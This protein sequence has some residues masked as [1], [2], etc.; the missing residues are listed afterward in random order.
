MFINVH[1]RKLINSIDESCMLCENFFY[2]IRHH[3][4]FIVEV[5][6]HRGLQTSS[7]GFNNENQNNNENKNDDDKNNG[8]IQYGFIGFI[9]DNNIYAAKI[10]VWVLT[11]FS[12]GLLLQSTMSKEQKTVTFITWNDFVKHILSKGEVKSITVH[13]YFDLVQIELHDD[14]IIDGRQADHYQFN[15]KIFDVQNFEEK[16]RNAEISLGVKPENRVPVQ[17]ERREKIAKVLAV[18]V[19]AAILF[20]IYRSFKKQAKSV[21]SSF[22]KANFTIID[23]HIPSKRVGIKFKDV[24]GLKEAKLEVMEFVDYLIKPK[25]FSRLGAKVPKGALLL[26]PPGCGKTLLA[27]ALAT[28]AGVPFLVMAGSE[29]VEL[30]GGLGAARVRSL[31]SEARK[32]S[33]CII[34]IDEIDAIG[35]QRGSGSQNS[36]TEEDQTLNQLLVELDGMATQKSVFMLA[37]TNRPEVLDKAL[38]RPGRFDRHIIIDLPNLVER[39]EIFEL[40]LKD[41]KL[42]APPEKYSQRLAQLTPGFSGAD[43][44][45]VV[46]EA[47]LHAVRQM[48]KIVDT[49]DLEY[50]VERVGELNKIL[51]EETHSVVVRCCCYCV[52]LAD[53][54]EAT[55]ISMSSQKRKVP[56]NGDVS[57]KTARC[58]AQQVAAILDSDVK[59]TLGFDED[60]PSDELETDSDDNVDN[61]NDSESDSDN[62]N[63]VDRLPVRPVIGHNLDSGWNKKYVGVNK[64]LGNITGTEK[65]S[66]VITAGEKKIVAYHESGHA[67]IGWLLEHTDALLKVTIVPRTNNLLGFAQYLPSDQ[68][69]YSKEQLLQR[70]C[71]A[72]GGRVAE[73]I[74]FNRVTSGAEDDL[75][76][77]TKMAYAY[78]K[79][80]GFSDVVGHLSFPQEKEEGIG[81]RPFSKRLANTI[82]EESRMLVAKAYKL[83]EKTLTENKD[84][85][86]LLAETLM[87]K[88]TLNYKEV[89]KLI[90]PPP[91][92]K[93]TLIDPIEL[94]IADR[95]TSTEALN[96]N[97]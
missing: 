28:E 93:K 2:H 52:I 65:R 81:R 75:K 60:N 62:E 9:T 90:G 41:V 38:L 6:F 59:E 73:S 21:F 15:M 48:H 31:F 18:C 36:S 71:M 32:R 72:L 46:N 61:E 56:E 92:G 5:I 70:M 78:V 69:L 85:L 64:H 26:G 17:F 96:N 76:K 79:Q 35:R 4:H 20:I 84:K 47:A 97:N 37:S 54:A 77:I 86:K 68:K 49:H 55:S 12:M 19:T 24:A 53:C 16:L 95:S 83:T 58:S 89:E 22:T 45:N 14:A 94:E 43:M 63:P 10:M 39:K 50:A 66:M 87:Q 13:P 23:P 3:L 1:S 34:Y 67:L 57:W 82:D 74:I 7:K 88:E 29:F 27:K 40:H 42:A 11:I 33:P 25:N 30:I 8:C 91:F 44:A 80:Y 51:N